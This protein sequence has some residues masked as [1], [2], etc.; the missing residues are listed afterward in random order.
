MKVQMYVVEYRVL[1]DDDEV[2]FSRSEAFPTQ[3]EMNTFAKAKR[4]IG[5]VTQKYSMK[6]SNTKRGF[7]KLFNHFQK[8]AR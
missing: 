1:N 6:V 4:E 3:R 5:Y 7:I 8:S 2:T